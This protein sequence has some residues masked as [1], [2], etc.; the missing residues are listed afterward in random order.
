ME[1]TILAAK[2]NF[3]STLLENSEKLSPAVTPPDGREA[4]LIA[5][6]LQTKNGKPVA[7]VI[8]DDNRDM[9]R[10]LKRGFKLDEFQEA[11]RTAEKKEGEGGAGSLGGAGLLATAGAFMAGLF[12][13]ILPLGGVISGLARKFPRLAKTVG[14]LGGVFKKLLWPITALIGVL[15]AIKGWNPMEANRLFGNES[16]LAKAG[17]STAHV[18]SGLT[19]GF[20]APETVANGL[21]YVTGNDHRA[22]APGTTPPISSAAPAAAGPSDATRRIGDVSAQYESR[23]RADTIST[24]ANDRGGKSYGEFQLASG[25]GTLQAYL[26]QSEYGKWFK[27]M[28]PG[29]PEFDKTWRDLASFPEFAQDQHD[30]IRRTHY[31]PAAAKAESLG[32]RMDDPRVQEAVWSGSVQ[33]GGW[34]KVLAETAG[35]EGF[36]DMDSEAQIRQLYSRRSDYALRHTDPALH[37]GIASRYRNEV[38]SVLATPMPSPVPM[39]PGAEP[40]NYGAMVASANTTSNAGQ[41]PIMGED[42]SLENMLDIPFDNNLLLMGNY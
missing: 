2:K 34:K 1:N 37:R 24:G 15:D 29:T 27:G 36:A 13:K 18:V 5:D 41:T 39:A 4:K 26:K 31:E 17:S 32:F 33:H 28:E 3:S 42:L 16:G 14:M 8:E 23:G 6:R 22:V 30:Y 40:V 19:L 12:R 9:T 10:I 35:T 7:D 11:P 25:T 20:V 38:E 21:N